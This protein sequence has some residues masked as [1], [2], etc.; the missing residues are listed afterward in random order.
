LAES[1]A[2]Q[3]KTISDVL[4]RIKTSIDVITGSTNKALE[5]FKVVDERVRAVSEQET[6][7]YNAMEEQGK[8]SKQIH[9]AIT[10]LNE[11]TQMVK[12]SSLEMLASSK[13][14]IKESRNLEKVTVDISGGMNEMASGTEQINSTVNQVEETSKTNKESIDTLFAEVSKFKV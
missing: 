6:H 13:E 10:K 8:G 14:V 12:R 2:Q 11:L 9:N 1:A 4:K 3:S 7:I 5:K